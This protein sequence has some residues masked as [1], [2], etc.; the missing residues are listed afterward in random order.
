MSE[1]KNINLKSKQAVCLE[2]VFNNRGAIAVLPTG[3]GKSL[4]YKLPPVLLA[5]RNKRLGQ[6]EG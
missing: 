1:Y 5:E 6:G 4:P 2:A 3:Y